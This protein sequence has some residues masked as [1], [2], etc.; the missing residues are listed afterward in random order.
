MDEFQHLR[1]V[2]DDRGVVTVTLDSPGRSVNVVSRAMLAELARVVDAVSG[3][4]SVR[5]LVLRSD[6]LKGFAAGADLQEV[7]A[8]ADRSAAEEFLN[9]GRSLGARLQSLSIPTLAL[10]HGVCV[11]GGL[12]LAMYCRCR[13][14]VDAPD[15][16]LGL[17][18]TK[19]GLIP[20]WGGTQ[21]LPE[22]I[23]PSRAAGMIVGAEPVAAREAARLGLVQ[24]A[25]PASEFDTRVARFLE[26][27]ALPPAR[28]SG[29]PGVFTGLRWNWSVGRLRRACQD[30][31][32]D[33][34]SLYAAVECIDAGVRRGRDAGLNT[35]RDQFL[36]ILFDPRSRQLLEKFFTARGRGSASRS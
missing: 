29:R 13:F 33:N 28:R 26:L 30:A 4:P 3:D 14:A 34:P 12:E 27:A 22:R 5:M 25:W 21:L 8:L 1:F 24:F 31:A 36:R 35:E 32:A 11:G 17:P 16:Q 15:T 2:R 6:K 20:G 18:E 9:A 7:R 19:L 10:L 23:G